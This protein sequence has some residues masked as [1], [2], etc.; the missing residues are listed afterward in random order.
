MSTTSSGEF[1]DSEGDAGANDAANRI[2]Q[3]LISAAERHDQRPPFFAAP[4]SA[5]EEALLKRLETLT[6]Q[7]APLRELS[8]QLAPLPEGVPA[9][10]RAIRASL[11]RPNWNNA[12]RLAPEEPP[13][14]T[15][16]VR[17]DAGTD[18]YQSS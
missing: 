1:Q 13:R 9:Q 11:A 10:L 12:T 5:F 17:V 18:T 3:M 15:V 4:S 7:L 2:L 8:P 16:F 14:R 6:A